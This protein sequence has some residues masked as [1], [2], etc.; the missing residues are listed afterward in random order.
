MQTH[1]VSLRDQAGSHTP[2]LGRMAGARCEGAG[3]EMT[4]HGIPSES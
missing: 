1:P 2:G 3:Q 4:A